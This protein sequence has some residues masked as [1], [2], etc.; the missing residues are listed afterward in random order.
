MGNILTDSIQITDTGLLTYDTTYNMNVSH[1]NFF[2][3]VVFKGTD[4]TYDFDVFNPIFY[5]DD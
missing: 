2:I 5:Y 4:G 3:L 1:A